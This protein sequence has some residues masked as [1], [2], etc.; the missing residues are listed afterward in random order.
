MKRVLISFILL[1]AFLANA[2]PFTDIP[3]NHWAV[4]AVSELSERG[5]ITGF[6]NGTFQ[7]G[8]TVTRYDLAVVI[9]RL[10]ENLHTT[11]G[12]KA[13]LGKADLSSIKKLTVEFADELSLL[14]VKASS[15]ENDMKTV[16]DDM[17]VLKDDLTTL[18]AGNAGFGNLNISGNIFTWNENLDYGESSV[19]S[20]MN[21]AYTFSELCLIM[22]MDITPD[23]YLAS[24]FEKFGYWN[25][26]GGD[27]TS[28]RLT[29]A[30]L[31]FN[32]DSDLRT[33]YSYVGVK[34]FFGWA[35]DMKFGR[36][37]FTI[38]QGLLIKGMGDGILAEK[39]ISEHDT[40][41]TVAGVKSDSADTGSL[42][43]S[44]DN[45]GIDL[46]Y[47]DWYF[48]LN[49]VQAELYLV[50][51][52]DPLSGTGAGF[53]DATVPWKHVHRKNWCG[54]SLSGKPAESLELFG[55][56]SRLRWDE[57]VDID[58][59]GST[60]SGDPGYL[61]GL[62]WDADKKTSLTLQYDKF[63]E[64]FHRP[65][66][67]N[68]GTLWGYNTCLDFD[69][70]ILF[71]PAG[72]RMNFD[73]LMTELSFKVS[74]KSTLLGRFEKI[75]DNNVYA[76]LSEPDSRKVYTGRY[77]YQ[78]KENTTLSLTYR[79]ISVNRNE[80]ASVAGT[81]VASGSTNP[82][83][84]VHGF[85]GDGFGNVNGSTGTDGKNFYLVDDVSIL[86]LSLDVC[87]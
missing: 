69:D 67:S 38:G 43:V 63:G 53:C 35:D 32:Q 45:A 7:G 8:K 26:S 54:L 18:K 83:A 66:D 12:L 50:N 75:D 81:Q 15:L 78:Y 64:W 77:L 84:G 25:T 72:Y 52:R 37:H 57:D 62:K 16:K 79:K 71:D 6:P 85:C 48:N 39:K 29:G 76:A 5:I 51:Q 68:Q 60:E 61:L 41:V 21:L 23:V 2:T 1:I 24:H 55:E 9:A 27:W 70:D 4:Q 17:T 73:D 33:Y 36:Q 42:G 80:T 3:K 40:T 31:N 59:N 47:T 28:G 19:G 87:F 86:R 13:K 56:Y 11:P 65:M 46:I 20:D 82:F 44:N 22:D 74:E 49:D 30:G 58:G 10:V 34:D 14:G